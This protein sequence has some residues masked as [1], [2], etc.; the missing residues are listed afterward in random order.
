MMRWIANLIIKRAMRTPYGQGHLYH[1]DG[2]LYMSRW[3]LFETR[4]L[5]ARV[6]HIATADYDRHLH[7]HPWNFWSIVLRGGYIERRP[8]DIDP[9]FSRFSGTTSQERCSVTERRAGSIARRYATDRHS[10]DLVAK[11]T[12]TL[13]IYGRKR[14]WWGFYTPAGKVYFADYSV[15]AKQ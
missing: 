15:L 9:C 8:V 7:D 13:F 1:E 5:S 11:D 2:S 4:F 6:H 12:W 3:I 14:Q 10:V